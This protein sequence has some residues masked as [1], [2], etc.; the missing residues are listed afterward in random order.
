MEDDDIAHGAQLLLDAIDDLLR[1]PKVVQEL[2]QDD[3]STIRIH[4]GN[5][6]S[7]LTNYRDSLGYT[8]RRQ[9]GGQT[10]NLVRVRLAAVLAGAA[11]IGLRTGL[12]V[13]AATAGGEAAAAVL[14]EVALVLA[15]ALYFSQ[16]TDGTGPVTPEGYARSL[17]TMVNLLV[18]DLLELE[19]LTTLLAITAAEAA[20]LSTQELLA[21]LIRA[22]NSLAGSA[23]DILFAELMRRFPGCIA[24]IT[25]AQSKSKERFRKQK[26]PSLRAPRWTEE[27]LR[28]TAD[29]NTAL[30]AV[31]NCIAAR[32]RP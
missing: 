31:R 28:L 17:K 25:R 13:G 26:N 24:A 4:R 1:N 29:I 18:N 30:N 21:R 27:W 2:S 12:G 20:A 14:G 5:V 3:L 15:A 8:R 32:I 22:I 10:R 19:T 9:S 23:M 7:N 16:L 6:A 11:P